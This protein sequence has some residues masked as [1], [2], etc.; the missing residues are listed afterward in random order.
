MYE[1][2]YEKLF[3]T[4]RNGLASKIMHRLLERKLD[5]THFSRVL[6]I[7]ANKGEHLPHV[8]HPFDEYIMSDIED[9]IDQN[10]LNERV[11]FSI[12]DVCNLQFPNNYFDRVIVTCVTVSYTHLT[13]PTS[14]LV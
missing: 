3:I 14:D 13:L 6:E 4:G 1:D 8:R 2:E 9:R 7:G 5:R 12:Q 10:Q 11:S